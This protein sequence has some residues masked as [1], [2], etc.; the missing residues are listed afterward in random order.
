MAAIGFVLSSE[1]FPA[2][3]LINLGVV[4]ERAG[5][6]MVWMSD[7]FHPWMDNQGH[8][9]QAWTVLAALG[10]RMPR[11]PLGTGVT[12]PT[13]RYHPAIVAQVFATLGILY[14]GRVFL[15]VGT[16]EAINEQTVSGEWGDYNERSDRLVE[17]VE[18]IR[19]LWSGNWVS[20]HG[21][22][23]QVEDA[24]LYSL[25]DQPIPIYIAA[26]GKE[27]MALAGQYGDGVVTDGKTAI[28][29]EMQAAFYEG[30]RKVG[31]N[32][33][34]LSIHAETFVFVGKRNSIQHAAQMWRFIPKAWDEY[35]DNP[36]PRD[37]LRNAEADVSL[38]EVTKDWVV[39]DDADT[40]IEAIEKLIESGVTHIYIHSGQ[41][42]QERVI[43]FYSTQVLPNIQHEQMQVEA[44]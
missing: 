2:L 5:F 13:Y 25:P 21:Q 18:L 27:S 1:Q 26:G 34:S 14:P 17:A 11:I 35:V 31:K 12:C 6:D 22:Y 41:E 10:Q 44:L 42:D 4:A 7:H 30:A 32:P 37:I 33:D 9:T 24:K 28:K 40:H 39:G 8:S 29:S 3:R 36:D 16:G 20:H 19:R 23:Y 43:A 38:E 15:G